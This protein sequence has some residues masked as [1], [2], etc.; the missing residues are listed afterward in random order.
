MIAGLRAGIGVAA[1]A[2]A[3]VLGARVPAAAADAAPP[4]TLTDI[5]AILDQEKADPARL[6]AQQAQA[7]AGPPADAD[8]R[9]LASFFIGRGEM[10][11]RLGRVREAI[12][13]LDQ[14]V[15]HAQTI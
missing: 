5:T 7:N 14:A 2:G 6:A 13:D 11:G 1:L 10:R 12:A 9:V 4:R 3:C 8:A 15:A